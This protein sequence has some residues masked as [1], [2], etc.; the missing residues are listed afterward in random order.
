MLTI[1]KYHKKHAN[2][3]LECSTP[4]CFFRLEQVKSQQM[5]VNG[6]FLIAV[7][8]QSHTSILPHHSPVHDT[9]YAH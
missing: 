4:L 1:L 9:P 5:C 7:N 8:D 6:S 3:K 2:L